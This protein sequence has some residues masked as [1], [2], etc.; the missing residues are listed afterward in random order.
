MP[1][2]IKELHI[3]MTIGEASR[4]ENQ[5]PQERKADIMA[6]KKQIVEECTATIMEKLK[7]R[8]ER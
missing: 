4:V 8:E 2:E 1:I 3:K 6:L 5:K 7:E